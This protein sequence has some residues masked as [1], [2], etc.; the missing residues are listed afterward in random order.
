MILPKIV[1]A[2]GLEPV[3]DVHNW[4]KWW[5][6]KLD[7]MAIAVGAIAVAYA[8]LP[9]DWQAALPHC[10]LKVLAITGLAIKSASMIL[11]GAKQPKLH[12]D[13]GVP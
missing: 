12:S 10:L 9:P 7:A 1:R 2:F 8:Q 6:A 5:S 13:G 3:D 4:Q 11:R